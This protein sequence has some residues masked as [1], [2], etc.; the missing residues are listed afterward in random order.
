MNLWLYLENFL[1][2]IAFANFQAMTV[3]LWFWKTSKKQS[4]EH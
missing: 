2:C 1:F 4:A 3:G